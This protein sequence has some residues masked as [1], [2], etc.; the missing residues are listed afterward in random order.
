MRMLRSL[1]VAMP[2]LL[3]AAVPGTS[4]CVIC[5]ELFFCYDPT[6]QMHATPSLF[7]AL[8]PPQHNYCVPGSCWGSH[9]P[10]ITSMIEQERL[11]NS[12]IN[13]ESE[14]IA[15]LVTFSPETVRVNP[16]RNALQVYSKCVPGL[17]IA[18][19]PLSKAQLAFV[20]T[21]A[22]PKLPHSVGQGGQAW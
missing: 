19:I 20:N 5:G 6:F 17:L 22:G 14:V 2:L 11:M 13:G 7:G 21:H 4:M 3:T 1:I 12:V 16:D 8:A 15:Q 18:H 9:G 10:C